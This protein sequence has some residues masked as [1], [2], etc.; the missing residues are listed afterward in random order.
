[1]L[2]YLRCLG[3]YAVFRGRA[4]RREYWGFTIVNAIVLLVILLLHA[5]FQT[6][7]VH[8]VFTYTVIIYAALTFIPALAV[9]VRRW[10]D[11]G[12]TGWWI[13]L[14]L[15]PGVGTLVSMCF[16]LGRGDRGTN[17]YGR[18]PRERNIR[19]RKRR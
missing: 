18:D 13:L 1:M 5:K 10:H 4:P 17:D 14:N 3:K 15:V 9:M 11:L 2:S 8:T 16:F 6:G 12:R 7:T 19:N